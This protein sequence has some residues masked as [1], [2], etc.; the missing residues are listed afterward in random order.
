MTDTPNEMT[1][2]VPVPEDVQKEA[3]DLA[4]ADPDADPDADLEDHIV[5]QFTWDWQSSK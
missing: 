2:T 1:I 5:D 3:R 4:N